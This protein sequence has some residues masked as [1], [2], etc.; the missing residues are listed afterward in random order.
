MKYVILG[1]SAAG[2]NAAKTIRELDPK[3]E[4]TVIS[5]DQEVYS[6]CMLHHIIS[7]SRLPQEINFTEDNFFEKYNINWLTGQ[8][9]ISLNTEEKTI[10]LSDVTKQSYDRLLIAT[11]SSSFMPP[12]E[13]LDRGKQVFGLRTIEDA[14]SITQA[15][16]KTNTA[17]VIGAGLIGMDAAYALASRGLKVTIIETAAHILPLQLDK[18]AAKKYEKLF[19]EHG[20]EFCFNETAAS[21]KL[22]HDN[23]VLG[24]QLKS[25]SFLDCGIIV[26]AAGVRPNTGFLRNTPV[27][28]GRGIKVNAYQ[29]TSVPDIYAAGDVCESIETFTSQFSLTPIWPSAVLQGR[30][31]GSNMAGIARQLE[32][33]FAFKNSMSFYGLHTVS[34]GLNKL[35]NDSYS[36]LIYRDDKNYKKVI[37]KDGLIRGAILQGD[38]SNA[39][40]IGKLV[41]DRI[42][43]SP[44][45][46]IFDLTYAN[47]FA[48]K[49]NGE[50]YFSCN[51]STTD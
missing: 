45:D 20:L 41:Q 2:I 17:V 47:F 14:R 22:D 43:I 37:L 34:F 7:G 13:N 3:G 19:R 40:L 1:A 21:V 42:N 10:L 28:I 9:A 26:V 31:A 6:R 50:F 24:V 4:I 11:G 35:P 30:V 8:E 33:N 44:P 15:A 27:S 18:T 5:K 36:E 51:N 48:Q 23:N 46:Q 39:G 25:G 38:I 16:E 49:E 29:Q 12:I 32:T